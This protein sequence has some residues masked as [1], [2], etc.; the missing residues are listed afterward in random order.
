MQTSDNIY[1]SHVITAIVY[2]KRYIKHRKLLMS[3]FF[4]F[5]KADLR[6]LNTI[7]I[8]VADIFAVLAL[9]HGK[10]TL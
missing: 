3:I 8:M 9:R 2:S 7:S 5:Y 1:C 4:F 10:I 6:L